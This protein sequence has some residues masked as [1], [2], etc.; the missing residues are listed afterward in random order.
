MATTLG[1][2]IAAVPDGA[3]GFDVYC[4]DPQPVA[5]KPNLVVF[6]KAAGSNT[7]E[8]KKTSQIEWGWRDSKISASRVR[9]FSSS[10]MRASRKLAATGV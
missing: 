10:P 2:L 5:V 8:H 9:A 6:T 1:N 4:M 3:G 7:I